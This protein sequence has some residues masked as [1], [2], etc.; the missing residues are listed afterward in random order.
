[1]SVFGKNVSRTQIK[2]SKS[3]STILYNKAT[4]IALRVCFNFQFR[5][6]ASKYGIKLSTR[7][8]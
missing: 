2:V 8:R 1:M 5:K 7:I 3:I 4:S 6:T